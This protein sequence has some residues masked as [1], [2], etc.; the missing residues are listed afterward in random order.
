M[1][2]RVL[3]AGAL[4][5]G[6]SAQAQTGYLPYR[7]VADQQHPFGYYLDSASGPVDPT[8]TRNAINRAV[9]SWNAVQCAAPK[10]TQLGLTQ[11]VVPNPKR[12]DDDFSVVGVWMLTA[13]ADAT[14][15][16]GT[17]SSFVAA[18]TIPRA[19]AGV[20]QTCDVYLKGFGVSWSLDANTPTN[21]MDVETVMLHEVGH[22][23]GLDHHG[24]INAVM[25]ASVEAGENRRVLTTED[26]DYFC[27][28]N[29][30]FGA[31]AAPCTADG[32]CN[33][34]NYKCLTQP[35]T[36]GLTVTRCSNGCSLNAGA[37]CAIPLACQPSTVFS[38]GGFNGA[39][40]LPG[41][42]ITAV[43]RACTANTDCGNSFAACRMP[44][45][46][47]T[48]NQFLWYG[49][50][51]TQ[52]CETGDP[53]CPA[54]STCVQLDTGHYC[55]QTCRVGLADC[56]PE[57]ACAP[58]D[59]IGTSGVCIPRCYG[60]QDCAD[61]ANF[62][63]RTCDGLCISRQG[64]SG[65]IGDV[66]ATDATCGAGQDCRIT[67]SRSSTKQCTTQCARGC[68][69]CPSGSTCTPGAGGELFCLKDCTGPGTCPIGLRCADTAVGKSCLPACQ[70]D[71]D[72]PV[73]QGCYMGECYTPTGD[74]AGPCTLCNK[75]DGGKP[76]VITPKDGG[77]NTGGTGGCGCSTVEPLSVML[78]ALALVRRRKNQ[79]GRG[80]S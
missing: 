60:D 53:A 14:A 5:L 2:P 32:G 43:G 67:D 68:A 9:D 20:L 22:C 7:M 72:C 70:I 1:S 44:E 4:V 17:N 36:N 3:L 40:L 26:V 65:Q 54:G 11:G 13:D 71:T 6:F 33:D 69:T 76:I 79:Q 55:T 59:T 47:S 16:F 21:F 56:R 39:C 34:A 25:N 19:Y 48:P 24:T 52:R 64:G 35:Q 29:P 50:Y 30:N 37:N 15:I 42:A 46:A 63:C 45:A 73:G 58:I 62:T 12:N 41:T 31:P 8:L 38:S 28:A 61:P 66:C 18:I 23:F 78:V 51:C 75:P 49:G 74:D 57:Y 80:R 77:V 10:M 27:F